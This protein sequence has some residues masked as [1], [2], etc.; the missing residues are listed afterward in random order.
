MGRVEVR[1]AVPTPKTVCLRDVG[2]GG[3]FQ[4]P[5]E[6]KA[7]DGAERIWVRLDAGTDGKCRAV[8]YSTYAS[9]SS[10]Y[11]VDF[12]DITIPVVEVDVEIVIG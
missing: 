5:D 4:L 7:A 2:L 9:T 10:V 3:F 6:R 8:R 11:R 1:A 12:L